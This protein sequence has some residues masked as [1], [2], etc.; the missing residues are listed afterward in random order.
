MGFKLYNGCPN[1]EL[2]AHWDSQDR[3]KAF[4]RDNGLLITYFPVE[5]KY[6]MCE[7][8]T[9]KGVGDWFHS[10]EQA[11]EWVKEHRSE[12]ASR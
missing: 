11:A 12:H 3:A 5:Q 2:Q 6:A 1:D 10:P 9:Y 7:Q 4:I 8:G